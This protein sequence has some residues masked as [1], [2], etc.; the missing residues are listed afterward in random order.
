MQIKNS[1]MGISKTPT[2]EGF[3]SLCM[4]TIPIEL[5]LMKIF[6]INRGTLIILTILVALLFF[7]GCYSEKTKVK[8][9]TV[10]EG[11]ELH[12]L[13]GLVAKFNYSNL[14]C[15]LQLKVFRFDAEYYRS[16]ESKASRRKGP[17]LVYMGDGWIRE[18][19]KKGYLRKIK[20]SKD[21]PSLTK[22]NPKVI[23][24]LK[25]KNGYYYGVPDSINY[26]LKL[27]AKQLRNNSVTIVNPVGYYLYSSFKRLNKG[28]LGDW[29]KLIM[30]L[31]KKTYFKRTV[32]SGYQMSSRNLILPL[33]LL[34][35]INGDFTI[36]SC[37]TNVVFSSYAITSRSKDVEE[38][39][40]FI[41]FMNQKEQLLRFVNAG[42]RFNLRSDFIS[43]TNNL[44]N[45]IAPVECDLVAIYNQ[46]PG[47]VSFVQYLFGELGI[48]L[49]VNN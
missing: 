24:N 29:L 20:N 33:N 42:L 14:D 15:E 7:T 18:F 6:I 23:V 49:G 41:K 37:S 26:Y 4:H 16:F 45:R 21:F 35:R 43:V 36:A 13:R 39:I 46:L 9:W 17:D 34:S 44:A 31:S 2:L 19:G 40:R 12:I 47:K 32:S 10:A 8:F 48:D 5:G 1:V 25:N 22:W 27:Q 28:S 11:E 38:S 3:S 30:S